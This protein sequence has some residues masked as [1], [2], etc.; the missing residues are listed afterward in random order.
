MDKLDPRT[1]G[2]SPN[3]IEKNIDLLRKLFPDAFTESS[4]EGEPRWKVDFDALRQILGEYTE[5]QQE[6]YGMNWN[7]KTSS[8]R[9]AQTPSTGT[10][11]PCPEES[12]RWDTTQNLFI[13]G[14][15]LEVLK[16]LQKSY[17]KKIKMI[18]IDPPYNTGKD[19]IYKDNYR[20]NIR[21]YKEITGQVDD[22]GRGL[23]SNPETSGRYHTD[24]LNMMYPRLKLARNLL[25]KDGVIFISIDD[26]E[27][28]NL[29]KLCDEILGE[30]NFIANI[31]WHKKYTRANDARWFSDN[32]DHI[33]CYARQKEVF[34]LRS[35][36][37][38]AKQTAAYSNP[39]NHPK[40]P[41]KATPLHAKSG[42][43]T[44]AYTFSNGKT[45]KPPIG[46]YR[47]YN[48]KS[49]REM[50][51]NDEIWFGKNGQQTPQRKSFLSEVKQGVTPIT[52]WQYKDVGHNHEANNELKDLCL[53]GIFSNPK[54]T[55]LIRRMCVLSDTNNLD[56]IVLDFFAGSATCAHAVLAQNSEDYGDRR[57]IMVQLPE[58]CDEK[59]Q[60]YRS[61]YKNIS[62]IGKERI[63]RAIEQIESVSVEP[64]H[65]GLDSKSSSRKS[66]VGSDLGFRV[67]KLDASNIK[68]WDADFDNLEE[69]LF[70]AV[71]NIK[72]DRRDADVLYELLI[73]YGLDLAVPIEERE[74]A[75]ETV[76]VIGAGA[77]V[78]CLADNISLEVVDGIAAI[79]EELEPEV[80]RVVFKDSGFAD[81]VVKTNA[82]QILRQATIEDVKSL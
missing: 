82:V 23:S 80:M 58:K 57:F 45:W 69:A 7:G 73:K 76:H 13:E 61:G 17:H 56:G 33:L 4:Y 72:P 32:H 9:I 54:P 30:E 68:P 15:N 48:D 19:Y 1:D 55:R 3:I 78:V 52:I 12:V 26:C 64:A 27:V 39:D 44:D 8:R 40:G 46:T 18:Y 16:L 59:S 6:R 14:D 35:L 49:M 74:I 34:V 20:N 50:E 5:D 24:W 29:R 75:G 47:R 53:G 36:P 31:V 81:D 38:N 11:R 51:K 2:S 22:T 41:W 10:L 62:E 25:R 65:E 42:S 77:L 67:F 66:P 71:D 70:D 28:A 37:R 43:D 79:K 63:R 60:A 21:N